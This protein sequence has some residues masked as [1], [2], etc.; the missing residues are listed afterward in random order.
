M[1]ANRDGKINWDTWLQEIRAI[2]FTNP[3]LNFESNPIGQID[4]ERAHPSGTAQLATAR[5]TVLSNLF[6]DPLAFSRAYS[7]AKRIKSRA[8]I[9]DSQFGVHSL[10]LVAGLVNLEHEGFDLSLPILIWN[11]S[12][13]RKTDDFELELHSTPRVNPGLIDALE[14]AYGLHLNVA[15]VL[16]TL[17]QDGDF[18]PLQLLEY[19]SNKVGVNAKLETRKILA[20]GNFATESIELSRSLQRKET[21]LLRKL[22]GLDRDPEPLVDS[23]ILPAI[24][25]EPELLVADADATQ[26]RVVARIVSGQSFAVETLPGCGYTQTVVNGI[27]AAAYAGKTVLVVAPRRQTLNELTERFS[28]LGLGGLAVRASNTWFDVI[29]AI[30]RHEKAGQ[31]DLVGARSRLDLAENEVTKYLD[32]LERRDEKLSLSVSQTLV[33][34]AQLSLLPKAPQT[35]ARIPT[36]HLNEHRDRSVALQLL[37]RAEEL[38]EFKYTPEET[39]WFMARFESEAEIAGVI[40]VARGLSDAAFSSIAT[41]ISTLMNKVSFKAA[42]SVS[43]WGE[44]IRLLV[45]IRETLG[46]FVPE[47][48]A[49]PLDELIAATGP[50]SSSNQM[51]GS[52]RRRLKKL[53]KEYLRPGMHVSDLHQALINIQ[54][55]KTQWDSQTIG[56]RSPDVPAGISDL[57]VAYQAFVSDLSR[58]QEHL[59]NDGKSKPLASLN[60]D[61]LRKTLKSLAENLE[62]LE[63]F[64]ERKQIRAQLKAAGLIELARD[65]ARLKAKREHLALEL[66]L[67]WWQSALEYLVARDSSI[68]QYT[69]EQIDAIEEDFTL[70]EEALVKNGTL[71]LASRLAAQWHELISANPV[72]AGQLKALLRNRENSIPALTSAAPS[73]AKSL[74]RVVLASPYEIPTHLPSDASFDI[75]FVVDAAG[76][77][78][79]ENLAAVSRVNQI[80]VFG[81]EAIA[82]PDG[83]EVEWHERPLTREESP[84]SIFAVTKDAFFREV[85]RKSWRGNGQTLGALINREFYQNRIDFVP[86]AREFLGESNLQVE[87]LTSGIGSS[88][89]G[90]SAVESPD[91]E[92]DH[93]VELVL[94]HAER[95]QSESLL[96][97]TASRLHADRI[98]TALSNKR[99]AKPELDEWFDSHGREKFEITPIGSL[100]HRSADRIIFSVG[101][102]LNGSGAAASELGDLTVT[103]GRRFLANMLVS[104]RNRI[105]IVSCISSEHLEGASPLMATHLLQSVLDTRPSIE[106]DEPDSDPL[107]EDLAMRLKKLGARSVLNYRRS[108]P[109]VVS[110]ANKAAVILPDW[111]LL[112]ESVSEKIRLRPALLRAMGW[113]VIRVHTFE[114]F[115]DPAALA[116]RIGES[117]G[118]QLTKRAQPLFDAAAFDETPEAWGDG[119]ESNDARLKGDKP[120][121]WG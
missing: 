76:T 116:V 19:I 65:L 62:P 21:P 110:Y 83:F 88:T 37:S 120:P 3:L 5:S 20:I 105:N 114:L 60:L 101:F 87:I 25:T 38:G 41:E 53:A 18:V 107:L 72:E 45:G 50:R 24:D 49:K 74:F 54:E 112:G 67:A 7:A 90:T 80:V 63:N 57:Q 108:L 44:Q 93:V 66:D 32:L 79:A 12:L 48:F 118:M 30:S 94:D 82:A 70:A 111:N 56:E 51:S 115:S 81:D 31:A 55:Q 59:D 4:L 15:E 85:L 14:V 27:A 58:V 75:A 47:V 28:A 61:E 68:M 92:V 42:H 102:G 98:E 100:S 86:P 77:T 104:A 73:I 33:A 71:V 29:A 8:D 106:Q 109:L 52:N 17:G 34:L 121:H 91:A 84:K 22:A 39:G 46:R 78:V 26:R 35:S 16:A 23:G 113:R 99:K 96:V 95:H 1:D 64:G 40:E 13:N 89:K 36:E 97:A 69:A 103:N 9:L 11:V 10:A 117:L 6:R 2:G 43:E 119:S